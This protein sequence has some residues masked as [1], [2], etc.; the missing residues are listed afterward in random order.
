MSY[1]P[2]TQPYASSLAQRVVL[3]GGQAIAAGVAPEPGVGWLGAQRPEPEQGHH[4]LGDVNIAVPPAGRTYGVVGRNVD[5]NVPQQPAQGSGSVGALVTLANEGSGTGLV[6]DPAAS[7]PA[8]AV[9]RSLRAGTNVAI[10]TEASGDILI[11]ATGTV[12]ST[13]VWQYIVDTNAL[14]SSVVLNPAYPG[15]VIPSDLVFP[16]TSSE[17]S[18]VTL[19]F[20]AINGAF[21]AGE[22]GGGQWVQA[23]RGAGSAAF[24]IN[25]T[26]SG[27]DTFVAGANNTAS[28]DG[29][30]VGAGGTAIAG[31]TAAGQD[32]F[33]G[34]GDSNA[35]GLF[36]PQSFI[37]AGV[38]NSIFGGGA[39]VGGGGTMSGGNTAGNADSFV[40]A[41]DGNS[42]T[43][44]GAFVGAGGT[45]GP[46]NTAA[47]QDS[48][49]GAG[50]DNAVGVGNQG[51]FIGAGAGNATAG[52]GAFVGAGGTSGAGNTAGGQDSFVGAGV[53][54]AAS[55]TGDFVG[56][57]STNTASGG[58]SFVGAG[59]GNTAGG[60]SAF[61]GAGAGNQALM[62]NDFVGGG[63]GNTA[64]GGS[65]FVG[66]GSDN[67]ASGLGAFIGAGGTNGTG[68]TAGGEDSFVGAGDS[69]AANQLGDFVGAGS[70]NT[71][72][73]GNSFVGAGSSNLASQVGAFIGAGG[74]TGTGNVASGQDSFVGAGNANTASAQGA[75]VGA[76]GTASAGNTAG[77]QDSFVGAGDGNTTSGTAAFVGAGGSGAGNAASG[78]DSF[79]GA[80][81]GNQTGSGA[82]ASFIGAG[83]SA[84]KGNFATSQ[85]SFIGAG[86][87][88]STSGTGAFVGAGGSATS[89][90]QANGQDSFIG[91]GDGNAAN[92]PGSFVGA[93]GSLIGGNTAGGDDSFVGAGNGNI[94]SQAGAFIGAGGT[95]AGNAASGQDAFVGAGDGNVASGDGAF[96]GAG[97][98]TFTGNTASGE[99][100]FVGGG[101]T[102][103]AGNTVDFVGGGLSNTANGTFS[104]VGGGYSNNA[105]GQGAF[106]G[107]GGTTST[108]NTASGQDSFVGG[109]FGNVASNHVDCVSGGG[110]NTASGGYS[111]VGGG[112]NNMA[113][114]LGAYVG[115]GGTMFGNGNTSSGQDAYV[116]AGDGNVASGTQSAVAGG[117]SNTASGACA[118]VGAGTGNTASADYSCIVGGT[119]NTITVGATNAF[120]AG[121]VGNSITA[122]GVTS[123]AAGD[124]ATAAHA[125]AFV[126]ADGNATSSTSANQVVMCA[127]GVEQRPSSQASSILPDP[128]VS[129]N[130]RRPRRFRADGVLAWT[131]HRLRSFAW[132]PASCAGS[133]IPNCCLATRGEGIL[134][135]DGSNVRQ[136][137][138]Q[139]AA[140][141]DITA[142]LPL[143]SGDLLLGTR[144]LGLLVYDGET[145]SSFHANLPILPL[146]HWPGTQ[147]ICGSALVTRGYFT[148][149]R[150]SL[151]ASTRPPAC[152]TSRWKASF[153]LLAGSSWVRPWAL[154]S[155]GRSSRV[156][157][158]LRDS[159]RMPWRSTEVM[160]AIAT[161]DQGIHEFPSMLEPT[162]TGIQNPSRNWQR[163]ATSWRSVRAKAEMRCS[164]SPPAGLLRRQRSGQW[165]PLVTSTPSMLADGN[166]SAL[167]FDPD[168]HLWIGYFDRGLDIVTF[169]GTEDS[170]A[171]HI[172]DDHIFCVN[173]I[174]TDPR[175]NTVDVATANG[176]VLFDAKGN[177][178]QT[179]LRRDGLV[180]D[181]V[182]DIA[183]TRDGLA[184]AT[185]AGVTLIDAT[186]LHSLYAFH[187]LVNNHVYTL[188]SDSGGG[189]VLAGTLGGLTMLRDG[190]INAS[191][192][193]AN[194]GLKQNWT[195]A[196]VPVSDSTGDRFL[197]GTYGSGVMQMD[198]SGHITAMEGATRAFGGQSQCDAG[199]GAAG[200]CRN[201]GRRTAGL[202]PRNA[203][204]VPRRG[205][206]ALAERH[207]ARRARRRTLYWYRKRHRRDRREQAR[208]V[209]ET[210]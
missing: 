145:L 96:V 54:N 208:P 2:P 185:P 34:A 157:F 170:S 18:G 97:G 14:G 187:G 16:G 109:G 171:R 194:S 79:I 60:G 41:G 165:Q 52:S 176:L 80:G 47:G 125:N 10:T 20:D 89:G 35:T 48:F 202:Q 107:A 17:A 196:I 45:I 147:A 160:L 63:D 77:G 104:F 49:I 159:L 123:F 119:T 210:S 146:Q 71:A 203:A 64:G 100:A 83:G 69:N 81:D 55:S 67:T 110:N 33:I 53:G 150:V 62:K 76:G 75:C 127:A 191:L 88:N 193:T 68:N 22:A 102:N 115:S 161:I 93:G 177:P 148:G 23:N 120:I 13:E 114:A 43:A 12:S 198:E 30:F 25:T 50:D 134:F 31:N 21:R 209:R 166:V 74:T 179:L 9:L 207:R 141:R 181:Q 139:F 101:S 106:I 28:S 58:G 90:N 91:A 42:T 140:A 149:T 135:Y 82:L 37:G 184:L 174:L 27:A 117:Q 99:D 201:T 189:R 164:Q 8:V 153:L 137:R 142:I 163:P 130:Y 108:G 169:T 72:G 180:A 122:A 175:R 182:N 24:G 84:G 36:A 95:S 192:T 78:Q 29:A 154:R 206:I 44:F 205:R 162:R 126:W 172:E 118:Y 51:A 65:S 19:I 11:N 133:A 156:A 6:Y 38:G 56:A 190:V 151:T 183:L 94:A 158:L 111:H 116:G 5:I 131:F 32:S 39:F 121:G 66:S 26:A 132:Q 199:H 197:I 98:T 173:R 70:G 144:Q 155:S 138:P 167:S 73:G 113:N 195:T 103:T 188:A 85:D 129:P 186:G 46:G 86:D 40:G 128:A 7:T 200:L 15:A 3:A 61:I 152:P 168:G 59:S 112:S 4:R 1:Y 204:L 87:G 92:G 178:R 124:S 57:G 136:L 105:T 143:S